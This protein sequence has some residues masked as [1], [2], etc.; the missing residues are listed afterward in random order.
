M[1]QALRANAG[2]I[3]G[4]VALGGAIG[5][6]VSWTSDL[7]RKQQEQE[8]RKKPISFKDLDQKA[9]AVDDLQKSQ[10]LPPRMVPGESA[11][12]LARWH[13][14]WANGTTN[15]HLNKPHPRL[16]EHLETIL[17]EAE[18]PGKLVLFPLCGASVDLGYL[19]R[20]GH[21]V[22]GVEG[23]P[24]AI[25]QLLKEWGEEI[26]S[27]GGLAPG[28]TRLRIATPGWW[29]KMAAEQMSK[30]QGRLPQDAGTGAADGGGGDGKGVPPTSTAPP[31][32]PAPFLFGV[33]GDFITFDDAA[34]TK[35]GL[36]NFDAAFDRGGL[37]AV[38]PADRP[39]Y[40]ANLGELLRPGGKLLLVAVEHTPAFGPPHSVDEVEVRRLL[41]DQ[42]DVKLLSREDRMPKE[43][44][45]KERG[46]TAFD[47]V[48]YLC[49]RKAKPKGR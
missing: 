24:A 13:E 18:G 29:Q 1:L 23:V 5:F 35:F 3:A 38:A 49:T 17:P 14:K 26:P 20:R 21:H 28:A 33:Q 31:F 34:A 22:V 47:E 15:W 43:P 36:G 32:E 48:T 44:V 2:T 37:V 41:G 25:D 42:F 30:A 6:G 46:A 9:K 4:G 40:A 8:E 45:W 10:N 7:K 11:D 27:G 19:A 16:Q 39:K 12:R